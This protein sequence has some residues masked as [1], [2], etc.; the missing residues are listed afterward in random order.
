MSTI[1]AYDLHNILYYYKVSYYQFIVAYNIIYNIYNNR[2]YSR[3]YDRM[4][5]TGKTSLFKLA[6]DDL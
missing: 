1:S 5:R 2:Y 4:N 6:R 3:L